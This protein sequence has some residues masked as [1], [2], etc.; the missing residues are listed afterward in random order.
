MIHNCTTSWTDAN[1][2]FWLFGGEGGAGGRGNSV[3]NDLWK[4]NPVSTEWTWMSG[5]S[6][7]HEQLSSIL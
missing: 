6:Q 5:E 1:G 4:F 2:H 7:T 3:F